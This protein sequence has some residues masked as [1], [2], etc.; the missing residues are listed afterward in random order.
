MVA[1]VLFLAAMLVAPAMAAPATKI[2][3][4]MAT[5]EFTTTTEDP[6]FSVQREDLAILHFGGTTTG[7]VS[8]TIGLDTHEGSIS[9]EWMGKVK[10]PSNMAP[11]ADAEGQIHAK[12]VW[13]FTDEGFTGTFE[14]VVQTG[15]IGFLSQFRSYI[16]YQMVLRG[17]G[18]FDGQTLKLSY[19]GAPPAVLEGCLIIPK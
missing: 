6:F 16:Y 18:D 7:S 9:G 3:G 13:T 14:G 19:S 10:F 5:I 2:E 1:V 8:L 17:T 15:W 12:H 4:V 11:Y